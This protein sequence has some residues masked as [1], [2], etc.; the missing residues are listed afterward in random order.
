MRKWQR[1]IRDI[2]NIE[3][4]I[5]RC[6]T[7]TIAMHDGDEIYMVTFNFGYMNGVFYIHGAKEGKKTD[8]IK[9]NPNV[10]FTLYNNSSL[11]SGKEACE[12]TMNFESVHG[13]GKMEIVNESEK[14]KQ[15]LDIIMNQY[16]K[17]SYSY[18]DK[19]IEKTNILLLKVD[20][21]SITG[22]SSMVD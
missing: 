4:V 19:M 15:A 14:K 12:Y 18:S 1:E 3:S 8:L 13:K 17:G 20:M 10:S 5:N 9:I 6:K 21:D 2:E 16:E 22:K 7:I 11:V